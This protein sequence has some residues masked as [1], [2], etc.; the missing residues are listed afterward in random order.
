MVH[1]KSHKNK[2]KNEEVD[3]RVVIQGEEKTRED[4]EHGEGSG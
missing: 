4:F 1:V 3:V 2:K